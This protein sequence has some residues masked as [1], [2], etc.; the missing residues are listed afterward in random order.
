MIL[1]L[2]LGS[3]SL[4]LE[5]HWDS[6]WSPWWGGVTTGRP[7]HLMPSFPKW[8]Y[9]VDTLGLFPDKWYRIAFESWVKCMQHSEHNWFELWKKMTTNLLSVCWIDGLLRMIVI[10][11][12][13]FLLIIVIWCLLIFYNKLTLPSLY[14]VVDIYDDREPFF[15][16]VDK[17]Q[18]VM[19]E[20]D[21][22]VR[23]TKPT[24]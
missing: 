20:G 15:V 1:I 9:Q 3:I 7:W 10:T 19:L 18:Y 11:V 6:C 14:H 24:W 8:E 13:I 23:D 12:I 5:L 16:R 2:V 22:F 21:F 4:C 17:Q